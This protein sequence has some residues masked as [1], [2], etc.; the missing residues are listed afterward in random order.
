M[1]FVSAL[2]AAKELVTIIPEVGNDAVIR[3]P[4]SKDDFIKAIKKALA[5]K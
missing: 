5:K 4:V 3:K 2:D 1:I